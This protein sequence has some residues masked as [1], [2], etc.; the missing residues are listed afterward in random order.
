MCGIAGFIAPGTA[1]SQARPLLEAMLRRIAHRGP[2]DAGSWFEGGVAIGHLRLAIVDLSPSGHQPMH[3]ASD[4]Y[5]LA[6]NGEIYNH[7][8]LRRELAARGVTF[9]G[10]S[11]TEVLLALI[12]QRGL[13]AALE[14]CVGMF[15]IVLWDRERREIHLARDR[16]GEK[17]LYYALQD[18]RLYFGSELKALA[19]HPSF[20][21][22]LDLDAVAQLMRFGY[23]AAP[24][25]IYRGARKLE[26][27]TV[28]SIALGADGATLGP[29]TIVSYWSAQAVSARGAQAPFQG[30][31]DDAVA[32]L[33]L[34]LGQAVAGQMQADVPL[35][36]M[37]SGG[38]DSSVV[39]ALMQARSAVPIRTY[40]IGFDAG[41]DEAPH[42]RAVARHLNTHHTELYVSSDDARAIIPRLA[43]LYDEP[44]GDSSQIPTSLLAQM[45]RRDV[46]VALSGDGGDEIFG[47]YPKYV[48]GQRY[49]RMRGR[50]TLASV[51]GALR[52]VCGDRLDA[53]VRPLSASFASRLS[54]PR[55]QM[56]HALLSA[57]GDDGLAEVLARVHGDELALVPGAQRLA[58]P[59]GSPA[60]GRADYVRRAMLLDQLTYLPG[61]IL[62]K[63]DRATMA[64]SLESRAPL[65]DHRVAELAATLPTS[66]LIEAGQGKRVLRELA[67][68]HV[69]RELLD[70]PKQGF[71]APVAE[72]LR[73]DLHA[74]AADL[75]SS[76]KGSGVLSREIGMQLLEAHRRA[77][78]D[79]SGI[80]WCMLSFLAWAEE[81]L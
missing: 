76:S 56:R 66:Y 79:H 24:H 75:I 25:S 80:L 73:T 78:A 29:P 54:A 30:T 50:R 81:W 33:E 46:T 5:V 1:P 60:T 22:V 7:A 11:D 23:I 13:V 36:A 35:G 17:P 38:I 65:L 42:A 12:E 27:G 62:T 31:F 70:R 44:L 18:G 68:R 40:C 72:W 48:F 45:V 10:H 4:R 14:S 21:R 69:P 20:E 32:A 9:R 74:W 15:A 53:W 3:S 26:P 6:F 63:V 55:M 59:F 28:M 77:L 58:T 67:F 52:H 61:D 57:G 71:S 34:T 16:F 51:L 47:G 19:A 37:L 41:F 43:T 2:D 64:A 8:E 49:A 39:A